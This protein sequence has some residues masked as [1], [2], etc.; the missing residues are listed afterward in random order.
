MIRIRAPF[1]VASKALPPSDSD[2]GFDIAERVV[3]LESFQR[4]GG[5]P[6][7]EFNAIVGG[8][9]A[10]VLEVGASVTLE[11]YTGRLQPV[12][13]ED[14]VLDIHGGGDRELAVL[15]EQSLTIAI[16]SCPC[17][18]R[19]RDSGHRTDCFVLEVRETR[20]K[21]R[22]RLAQLPAAPVTITRE[23]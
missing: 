3:S 15:A 19:E 23:V 17:T 12:S 9:V 21:L 8:N 13:L 6:L 22:A 7:A 18:V 11:L 5:E 2:F 10:A 14:E 1:Y 16:Q 4:A 20:D